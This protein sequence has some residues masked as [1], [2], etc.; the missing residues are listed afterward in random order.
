MTF[1]TVTGVH[2]LPSTGEFAYDTIS[3]VGS[4]RGSTGLNN[5]T[6]LNFFSSSPGAPT[7]YTTAITQ[8]QAEHPGKSL[9][10]LSSFLFFTYCCPFPR[11]P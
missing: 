3:A 6:I 11:R 2:L 1:P 5:A 4:Q 9:V 7:D 8:F 10:L